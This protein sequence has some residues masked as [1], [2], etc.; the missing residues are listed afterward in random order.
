MLLKSLLCFRGRDTGA[1]LAAVGS[2]VYGAISITALLFGANFLLVL[3]GLATMP[4]LGLAG[5]RRLRDADKPAWL[6]LMLLLPL[7]AYVLVLLLGAG[8]AA[9]LLCLL[10]A[11]AALAWLAWL[12]PRLSLTYVQGYCGPVLTQADLSPK[13][14]RR[15]EPTLAGQQGA[16][17]EMA[18]QDPSTADLGGG[19]AEDTGS[20]ANAAVIHGFAAGP[21]EPTPHAW[22]ES[23]PQGNA[24]E[25]DDGYWADKLWHDSQDKQGDAEA[26]GSGSLTALLRQGM[27][28]AAALAL[29]CRPYGKY[30]GAGLLALGLSGLVWALWPD[31]AA[32]SDTPTAAGAVTPETAQRQVRREVKF[33]DGFSL[34]LEGEVLLLRWLGDSGE[35]Q[36]LWSLADAKG[37]RRCARLEFNNGTVYRPMR[38][39]L[40]A[41]TATEARFSPLDTRDIIVDIAR[42]GSISLCGYRFDLKGSQNTLEQSRYFADYLNQG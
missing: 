20:T 30:L 39:T 8:L 21:Q 38:V 9:I 6:S 1:R 10:P 16:G 40:G 33:A 5:Y 13:H 18:F 34:Q 2:A 28:G 27:Q 36:T 19:L 35:P 37:D 17:P 22:Q 32:P 31:A 11:V 23:H 42:R 15:V 41:D 3:L 12:P 29:R 4:V 25:N 7:F 14:R 26:Y 24:G